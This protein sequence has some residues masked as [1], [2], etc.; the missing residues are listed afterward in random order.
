AN[1]TPVAPS[2][3]NITDQTVC[4]QSG[5]HVSFGTTGAASYNLL[6]DGI[7]VAT[8]YNSGDLYNPG[9]TTSHSYSVQAANGACTATSTT[10]DFADATTSITLDP[11]NP[12]DGTQGQAY[13]GFTFQASGGTGP[14]SFSSTGEPAGMSVDTGGLLSGTPTVNG[15]FGLTITA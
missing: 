4:T 15:S 1:N 9:D 6:Q 12:P 5:I 7:T 11:T 2:I 10:Q 13:A 8:G 14:Y 3:S